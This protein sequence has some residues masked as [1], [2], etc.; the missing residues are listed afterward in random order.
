M[1]QIDPSV[2]ITAR[3]C[4]PTVARVEV[5]GSITWDPKT[6]DGQKGTDFCSRCGSPGP[7]LSRAKLIQ[8]LKV[9]VQESNLEVARRLELKEVLDRIADMASDDTKAAAGW[10]RLR[11]L[12]PKVW[13]KARPVID[14]LAAEVVKKALGL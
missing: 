1:N 10:E 9:Q 4:L 8:W 3:S 13:E 5:G 7:W 6:Y 11:S 14:V 2:G 12:A